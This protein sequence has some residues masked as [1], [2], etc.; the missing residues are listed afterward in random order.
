MSAHA[1]DNILP[2]AALRLAGAL[3]AATLALVISVQAGLLD[4]APTAQQLRVQT[5]VQPAADRLLHFT[6]RADGAV[7]A[8]D[9]RTGAEIAV[10][11]REGGGFIRGVMRGLARERRMHHSGAVAPFRLTEW[12]DG[13]L[14]LTDTAT[15]RI[16][17]LG[18]FGPDNRAAFARLLRR[19]A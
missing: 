5:G 12:R 15:G 7:V 6:D 19:D 14:S 9:A 17:E 3:V 2:P 10:I 18:S 16:I 11:G 13:A 8:T 4:R 1:H